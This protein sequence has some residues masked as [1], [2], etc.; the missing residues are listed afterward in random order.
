MVEGK[1]IVAHERASDL[2]D[3]HLAKFVV[4]GSQIEEGVA[5]PPDVLSAFGALVAAVAAAELHERGVEHLDLVD[6]GM[7]EFGRSYDYKQ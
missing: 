2:S 6:D 4:I 3:Q 7:F 5:L 1:E